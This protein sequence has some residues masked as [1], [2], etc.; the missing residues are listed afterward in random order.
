[1]NPANDLAYF[2]L[3]WSYRM[4]GRFYE[5]EVLVKKAIELNPKN[6]WAY[7]VLGKLYQCNGKK[8]E[9]EEAFR[10]AVRLEPKA[11]IWAY[12]RL[13]AYFSHKPGGFPEAEKQLRKSVELRPGNG[14]V[15]R[16]LE[17]LYK[18]MDKKELAEEY[19]R[20]IAR[21]ELNEYSP[22]AVTNYRKLKTILDRRGVKFVCMQY[23]MRSVESLKRIFDDQSGIIFVDNEKIFKKAVAKGNYRDYFIDNFAG[24]FGHCNLKGNKLIA[25]N[26][27]GVILKE[28][29]H[30]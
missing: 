2:G 7:I 11:D 4:A 5:A 14:T 30:R 13:G 12:A 18:E 29:S 10:K 6:D 28:L 3:G 23:P 17:S 9:T 26:L 8:I 27:A 22:V 24:D 1:M 15:Y 20:K 19:G 25:A 16:A 21:F